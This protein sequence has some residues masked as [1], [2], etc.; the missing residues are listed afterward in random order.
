MDRRFVWAIVL[1]MTIVIGPTFFLKKPVR[2]T[3]GRADSTVSTIGPAPATEAENRPAPA[4]V[5]LSDSSA[6]APGDTVD[7][8]SPLYRYSFSTRGAH[9][10]QAQLE[11]YKALAPAEKGQPARLIPDGS[12]LY[13]LGFVTGNDTVSFADWNFAS[14]AQGLRVDGAASRR[15]PRSAAGWAPR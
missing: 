7:V 12:G 9:L 4:P 5:G 13:Q 1:M 14:S 10:I 8:I 11:R 6:S 15:S 3:A 2:P